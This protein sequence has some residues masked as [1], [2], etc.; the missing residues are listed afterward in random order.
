MYAFF[1][2]TL[3]QTITLHNPLS[4]PGPVQTLLQYCIMHFHLCKFCTHVEKQGCMYIHMCV[5]RLAFIIHS[6]TFAWNFFSHER[7]T[8]CVCKFELS[9]HYFVMIEK[10]YI[11]ITTYF[12]S[13]MLRETSPLSC[14]FCGVSLPKRVQA[15]RNTMYFQ[16]IKLIFQTPD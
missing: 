4:L 5:V 8:V 6:Q 13:S 12:V 3:T 7:H 11:S 14:W 10:K 2:T 1:R 15:K 9:F 16:V